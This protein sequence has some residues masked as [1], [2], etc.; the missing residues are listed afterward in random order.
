V[1]GSG[2]KSELLEA[3]WAKPPPNFSEFKTKRS[4]DPVRAYCVRLYHV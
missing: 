4:R 3:G 1:I 2:V